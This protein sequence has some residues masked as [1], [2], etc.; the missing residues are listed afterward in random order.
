MTV[1]RK[2][3]RGD[4]LAS[5]ILHQWPPGR[6]ASAMTV[7]RARLE[8]VIEPLTGR[9]ARPRP[10]GDVAPARPPAIKATQERIAPGEGAS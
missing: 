1:A 4:H 10:A 2:L 5:E 3:L 7:T 8:T 6:P 9:L